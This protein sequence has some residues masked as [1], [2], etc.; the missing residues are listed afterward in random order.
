MDQNELVLDQKLTKKDLKWIRNVDVR[1]KCTKALIHKFKEI[2]MQCFE[3]WVHKILS[4][5][6][7]PSNFPVLGPKNLK[8]LF[9]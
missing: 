2:P 8:G 3:L 9:Y 1:I 7:K 4:Q 5:I 6:S